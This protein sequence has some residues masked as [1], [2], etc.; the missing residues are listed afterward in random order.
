MIPLYLDFRTDPKIKF[1]TV[2]RIEE[3]APRGISVLCIPCI[4]PCAAC[5]RFFTL[6]LIVCLPN[7]ASPGPSDLADEDLLD[8]LLRSLRVSCRLSDLD[9][10]LS[11]NEAR[12]RGIMT[13]I[14]SV[15]VI[16]V[17]SLIGLVLTYKLQQMVHDEFVEAV[18]QQLSD[19]PRRGLVGLN[20]LDAVEN[21]FDK[22]IAAH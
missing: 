16:I 10:D 21:E 20:T 11:G 12:R 4:T 1:M 9:L 3:G 13:A 19:D 18:D 2:P 15:G 22:A 6:T 14:R 17:C 7:R 5:H 8:C